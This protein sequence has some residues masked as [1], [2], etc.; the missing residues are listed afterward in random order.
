LPLAAMSLNQ[1]QKQAINFV[2]IDM[3]MIMFSQKLNYRFRLNV[4]VRY[5]DLALD[6]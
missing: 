1:P 3:D 2:E 5:I 6:L 4:T